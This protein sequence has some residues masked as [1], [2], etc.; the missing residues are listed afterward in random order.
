MQCLR[1]PTSAHKLLLLCKTPIFFICCH[2]QHKMIRKL[3]HFIHSHIH[4]K[5]SSAFIV[6]NTHIVSQ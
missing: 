5:Q 6:T 2:C 1:A 3:K 4:S